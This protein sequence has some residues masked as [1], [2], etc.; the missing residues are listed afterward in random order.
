M[1]IPELP[2]YL[3]SNN[4]RTGGKFQ[5]FLVEED[6]GATTEY[7]CYLGENKFYMIVKVTISGDTRTTRYCF[8]RDFAATDWTNRATK[9]YGYPYE[10]GV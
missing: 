9:T 4:L 3:V 8:G 2:I 10:A 6:L 5:G 1:I 7:Y